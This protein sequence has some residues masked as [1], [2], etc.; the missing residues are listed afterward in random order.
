MKTFI[1]FAA[2]LLSL[3][4]AA[5]AIA[6]RPSPPATEPGSPR[7]NQSTPAQGPEAE[8]TVE[9][10]VG[11][12]DPTRTQITLTDGTRLLTP[13]GAV[14]KPGV[15]TEGMTVVASYREE[16]GQKVLTGLA[17]KEK[18]PSSSPRRN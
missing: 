13:P 8:K 11:N 9:G 15:L 7:S 3:S 4:V 18:A 10:Q 2:M 12:I 17:V 14:V 6:Q 5:D 16:N 1:M